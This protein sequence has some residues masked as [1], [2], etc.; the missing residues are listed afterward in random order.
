MFLNGIFNGVSKATMFKLLIYSICFSVAD[1][2]F[3]TLTTSVVLLSDLGDIPKFCL[4]VFCC[5]IFFSV[6]EF[7]L[8][9]KSGLCDTEIENNLN[10]YYLR[11]LYDIKPEV[12]KKNNTG[13]IAGLVQKLVSKQCEVIDH[14][15]ANL[16]MNITF[17]LYYT[18]YICRYSIS[19][20]LAIPTMYL[21]TTV[22]RIWYNQKISLK[23]WIEYSDSNGNKSRVF[24]DLLSNI[25]T[26]QKTQSLDF[27]DRV[28]IDE[29]VHNM[30][31]ATK[32]RVLDEPGFLIAKYMMFSYVIV[33]LGI[34]YFTH[35]EHLLSNVGFM[36]IFAGVSIKIPH[37]ARGMYKA[38]L[39]YGHFKSIKYKI[40]EIVVKEN[41]RQGLATEYF[42]TASIQDC[43]YSYVDTYN[44]KV[45]INIPEFHVN[46]GDVICIH[47]ESGQGKTT[48]LHILSKEIETDCVSINGKKVDERLD[49]VFIAQDTEMLD[50]S[51]RDNLTLGRYFSDEEL[52][53]YLVR[54][55]M[56]EWLSNQEKGLDTILGER[57]VFVSTGQRQR[58]NLIRGLLMQDKEIYL[59]DEPTS[60]V[61]DETEKLLIDLIREKLAGKTVIIVTH[62]PAIMAI[63]NRAYTFVKGCLIE[64]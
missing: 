61:D 48:L 26:I 54:V 2:F 7:F 27:V 51:L 59:L 28:E 17:M 19:V 46:R 42:K 56:G 4:T 15:I 49:C 40:D 11:K 3:T 23:S 63:C 35:Q 9:V 43:S 8:D 53:K 38:I 37:N 29:S 12:I 10:Q 25:N 34:I 30:K 45:T 50:M 41:I 47:G 31:L 5:L 39:C 21:I 36:A 22:V 58:L 13:Y 57:G 1:A 44:S 32:A 55:G 60:N 64:D 52:T 18:V 62:R 20:A 16:P 6:S 33:A 14:S 24:I